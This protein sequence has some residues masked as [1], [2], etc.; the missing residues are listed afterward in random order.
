MKKKNDPMK[1][2]KPYRVS[3]AGYLPCSLEFEVLADSDKCAFELALI[4][5]EGEDFDIDYSSIN[6][7][8]AIIDPDIKS[9]KD[10]GVYIERVR[11]FKS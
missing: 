7:E 9:Y 4:A 3:L 2:M 10:S 6:Y 8:D 5:F 11:T 1:N